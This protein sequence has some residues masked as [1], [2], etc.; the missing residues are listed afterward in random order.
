MPLRQGRRPIRAR[1]PRRQRRINSTPVSSPARPPPTTATSTRSVTTGS[2][3]T[4]RLDHH[5]HVLGWC[6]AID[7]VAQVEH[8]T[9]PATRPVE[10][11]ADPVARI[12]LRVGEQ[13]RRVEVPLDGDSL[14]SRPRRRRAGCASRRRSRS[15]PPGGAAGRRRG[16]PRERSRWWGRTTRPGWPAPPGS[17][18]VAMAARSRTPAQVSNSCTTSAPASTCTP[19]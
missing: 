14:R 15:P 5:R 18:T 10:H 17:R 16:L 6:V 4:Y 19:R 12:V 3:L 8:V 11:L 13:R 9:G 2:P 7:A 1:R